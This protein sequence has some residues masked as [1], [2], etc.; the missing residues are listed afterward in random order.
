M[1]RCLNPT[2]AL[3]PTFETVTRKLS[4]NATLSGLWQRDHRLWSV[5]TTHAKLLTFND[6]L[7]SPVALTSPVDTSAGVGA[8]INYVISDIR[9]DW[10][11]ISGATSYRWQLDYD[12]DFSTVPGGFED[13]TKS[14][15]ARLPT[16]EPATTYY[17]RVR[18]TE[19]VLSP[20]S[21]KWSFT[22]SLDTEAITLNL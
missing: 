1:E 4:D 14:S 15:S 13:T 19:P 20:W 16:L 5:D 21:A 17:W 8:I 11:V 9:L 22:T 18:A 12:T 10:E 6:S 7:T 2:Y 3:G